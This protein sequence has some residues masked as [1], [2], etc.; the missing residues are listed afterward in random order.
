ME[1]LSQWKQEYHP[2][3]NGELGTWLINVPFRI[4]SLSFMAL[5]Q[6]L[7]NISRTFQMTC[8]LFRTKILPLKSWMIVLTLSMLSLIVLSM[9]SSGESTPITGASSG[10]V[11][12]VSRAGPIILRGECEQNNQCSLI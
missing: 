3:E 8:R 12:S 6:G 4:I 10:A 5:G 7:E 1:G 9:I 2:K 11:I